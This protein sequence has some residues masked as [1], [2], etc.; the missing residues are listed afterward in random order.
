MF[1]IRFFSPFI[2]ILLVIIGFFHFLWLPSYIELQT[3]EQIK[4]EN[5]ILAL[6]GEAIVPS[7]LSSDYGAVHGVVDQVKARHQTW[8][9][10][11]L[12]ADNG[13]RLY[14]LSQADSFSEDG[15]TTIEH[16][17]TYRGEAI[18]SLKASVNIKGY[19][20]HEIDEIKEFEFVVIGLLLIL[21]AITAFLQYR[22]ISV[23]LR[24]L[25]RATSRIAYGEYDAALPSG[26]GRDLKAY[27]SSFDLMREN[28]KT[29][30][31]KISRQQEIEDTIRDIQT[32]F[33]TVQDK[34]LTFQKIL[35]HIIYLT[36]SQTGLIGEIGYDNHKPYLDVY[37]ISNIAWNVRSRRMYE[38]SI[39]GTLRF[40]NTDNLF[41]EVML[42]GR[43]LISNDPMNDPRG[44][45]FPEGHP[46]LDN[47]L[48]VPLYNSKSKLMGMIG[49][50]NS[51]QDYSD[52]TI[53]E[54]EILWLAIGNL[55]D[56][57]REHRALIEREEELNLIRQELVSANIRLEGLVRTDG[58]T[59]IANRRYFDEV[60]EEEFNRAIRQRIALALILFDIDQFK[61]Y[62]D[63]YGHHE[64]DQC[65]IKIA[66]AA[67]RVFQRSG[68][69]VARYGG[70]EFAV[71]VP[72][73]IRQSVINMADRLL[74]EVHK[75]EI[76]HA[77]SSVSGIVTISI[78]I[79]T[80]EPGSGDD[81]EELIIMADGALYEAKQGGRDQ[82]VMADS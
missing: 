61:A 10:I 47:F 9:D 59:N 46:E 21:I 23:P 24:K 32:H 69:L 19:L 33:I 48:G 51:K 18:G 66:Q 8:E 29:R 82:V 80:I 58:L 6:L 60:L 1:N 41:G 34:F 62:N 35:D 22:W 2:I 67:A 5:Q 55:I 72:Y 70:E 49:V 53:E 38:Q 17:I 77:K 15:Y 64:G 25:A 14:P 71:I 65:L 76:P 54:L 28:L 42:T 63:H 11:T 44:G 79:A 12:Y 45:G 13:V 36:G 4:H 52:E 78:G 37:A 73:A 30:E 39:E 31:S 26:I 16:T 50:A 74:E 27:I 40:A 56:A 20:K 43:A 57:Q 75:L 81:P 3:Q 68:E 7:L